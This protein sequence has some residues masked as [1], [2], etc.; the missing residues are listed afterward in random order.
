MYGPLCF[1]ATGSFPFKVT[2]S[3]H[4]TFSSLARGKVEGRNLTDAGKTTRSTVHRQ[5]AAYH[6]RPERNVATAPCQ[7]EMINT[8]YYLFRM[9][10]E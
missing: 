5:F 9:I 8:D 6:V 3:S 10:F 2:R 4:G 1:A 7:A